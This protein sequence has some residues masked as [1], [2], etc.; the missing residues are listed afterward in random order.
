V[1]VV[2]LESRRPVAL[3]DAAA[4]PALHH[5]PVNEI[6]RDIAHGVLLASAVIAAE[7]RL[8]LIGTVVYYENFVPNP[9]EPE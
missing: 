9:D 7:G 2:N 1:D 6:G 4:P 8:H 3:A 5:H